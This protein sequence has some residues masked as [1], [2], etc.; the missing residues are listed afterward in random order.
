MEK[1]NHTHF[2]NAGLK[3]NKTLLAVKAL[4]EHDLTNMNPFLMICIFFAS[5]HAIS[6]KYILVSETWHIL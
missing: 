6:N 2:S 5:S 3:Q 1:Q 4:L